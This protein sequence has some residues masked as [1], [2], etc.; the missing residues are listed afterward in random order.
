MAN[1]KSDCCGAHTV[2]DSSGDVICIACGLII[3]NYPDKNLDIYLD[4]NLD[5][6]G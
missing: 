5:N 1:G 4:M 2:K 3:D 6:E